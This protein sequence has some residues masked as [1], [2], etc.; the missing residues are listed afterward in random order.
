[1]IYVKSELKDRIDINVARSVVL[2]GC[3]NGSAKRGWFWTFNDDVKCDL[4]PGEK[5]TIDYSNGNTV[6]V[7][8]TGLE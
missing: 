5:V 3:A 1:M 6:V 2:V 8:I 4:T 7:K